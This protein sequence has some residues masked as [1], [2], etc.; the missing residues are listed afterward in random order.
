MQEQER[1]AAST[2]PVEEV[3]AQ[4][5]DDQGSVDRA[6]EIHGILRVAPSIPQN[7]PDGSPGDGRGPTEKLHRESIRLTQVQDIAGC[8]VV[9]A[10][11][12]EQ[13][14]VVALLREVVP[15]ASI[16][17]RRE[18]PSHG[19]RAVHLIVRISGALVDVQVRTSAQHLWAELSEKLSDV[20]DPGIKY[21]GGIEF[22]REAL[23]VTSEALG[24]SEK[25]RSC[26]CLNENSPSKI[27]K[28]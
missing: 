10:D 26:R 23:R 16:V 7:S 14:G 28:D 2:A 24:T 27:A 13:D 22:A 11:I 9:V 21:G 15:A 25:R 20:V 8:R 4:A 12:R 6:Q 5:V 17:D 19:Y 3:K 18:N 1:R